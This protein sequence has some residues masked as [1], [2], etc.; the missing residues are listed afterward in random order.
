MMVPKIPKMTI[1]GIRSVNRSV[2]VVV[3]L[4]MSEAKADPAAVTKVTMTSRT[5][6][7]RPT[8]LVGF[9]RQFDGY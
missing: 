9:M 4:L 8:N 2:T 5:A 7:A 3:K 6:H 1:R